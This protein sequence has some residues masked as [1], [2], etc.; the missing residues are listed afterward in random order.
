MI[1]IIIFAIIVIVYA[2]YAYRE[3]F[4][5]E[6]IMEKAQYAEMLFSQDK[7]EAISVAP[8]VDYA[9]A[10]VLFRVKR[11]DGTN[12]T[13]KKTYRLVTSNG[14]IKDGESILLL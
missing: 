7:Y 4:S 13:V 8:S 10:T 14:D 3:R 1:G 9:Y 6:R 11:V 5:D 12:D 2:L